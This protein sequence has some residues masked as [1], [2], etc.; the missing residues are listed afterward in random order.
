MC[1]ACPRP[2][3]SRGSSPQCQPGGR[4]INDV[5][6]DVDVDDAAVMVFLSGRAASVNLVWFGKTCK[7]CAKR[8]RIFFAT[9]LP[10]LSLPMMILLLTIC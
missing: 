7:A 6:V 9:P 2:R 8:P 1:L 4:I 5:D 10:S 3:A